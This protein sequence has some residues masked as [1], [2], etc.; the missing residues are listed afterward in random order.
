MSPDLELRMDSS[1]PTQGSRSSSR[2]SHSG[3]RQD[4]LNL[5]DRTAASGSPSRYRNNNLLFYFARL[6]C[7][8]FYLYLLFVL[9]HSKS[10]TWKG[11]ISICNNNT[12]KNIP[13]NTRQSIHQLLKKNFKTCRNTNMSNKSLTPQKKR[14]KNMTFSTPIFT[15]SVEK[16][17]HIHFICVPKLNKIPGL[18]LVSCKI[19][20]HSFSFILFPPKHILRN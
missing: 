20:W 13:K 17:R 8:C 19:G 3:A 1:F 16:G 14:R 10:W 5:G 15:M 18:E 4:R 11:S 9:A 2:G 7:C 6:F 12:S